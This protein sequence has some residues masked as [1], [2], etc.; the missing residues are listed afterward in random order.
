VVGVGTLI[1]ALLRYQ[2]LASGGAPAT[3]DAGNWLAFGRDMVGPTLRP[4]SIYPPL[5]PLVVLGSIQ[6]F[7]PVAGVAAVA[8]AASIAPAVAMFTVLYRQSLGWWSVGL[9][10]LVLAAG[11]I[12]E[13]TAWGGF[14]QLFATA[15]TI[16]FLWRWDQA[17]REPTIRAG[18]TSG[19]LLALITAS[20]HLIVAFALLAA[21]LVL[22]G[23]LAFQITQTGSGWRLAVLVAVVALPS[24]PFFP[25]Y[26]RLSNTVLANVVAR[27]S[28]PSLAGWLNHLEFVYKEA[29]ILWRTVLLGCGLAVVLLVPRRRETLWL[30]ST[31]MF[32]AALL[33]ALVTRES[34]FLYLLQ[35][36]AILAIGLWIADIRSFGEGAFLV[37]RRAAAVALALAVIAQALLGAA[38]FPQQRQ[39]YAVLR[40]G[41]VSAIR[42]LSDKTPNSAVVAVSRVREAPL[43]WWVEGLGRR[44]TLYASSLTW[45]NFPDEQRR[46]RVANDIFSPTFPSADGLVTACQARVSYVLVAKAWGGF[47]SEQLAAVESAHRGAVVL[48]NSD[49]VVLSMAALGCPQRGHKG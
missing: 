16:V 9:A 3:I 28:S 48:N 17:L 49:A 23:H 36:A 45:L 6:A 46:A 40:P 37:T 44:P 20:S 14:P 32:L 5:V 42:W 47:D 41:T 7:G 33:L 35:P 18:L 26:V 30:L 21:L 8:V 39:F 15:L 1:F 2:V 19:L 12:G 31:C 43:G 22:L 25:L 29:P 38:I 11:S 13:A 4:G 24:L 10:A 34:R 27:S